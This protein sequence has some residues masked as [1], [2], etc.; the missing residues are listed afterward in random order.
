MLTFSSLGPIINCPNSLESENRD[1][2]EVYDLQK[3]QTA[4]R[5]TIFHNNPERLKIDVKQASIPR[6]Y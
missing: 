3:R 2:K 5:Y 4:A 1:E 6:I